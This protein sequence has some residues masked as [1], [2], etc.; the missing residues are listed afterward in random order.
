MGD[1]TEDSL[2]KQSEENVA[3]KAEVA[4]PAEKS[5]GAASTVDTKVDTS[6][7]KQ[8]PG[9]ETENKDS[10]GVVKESKEDVA[11]KEDAKP[12]DDAAKQQEESSSVK[13]LQQPGSDI[14]PKVTEAKD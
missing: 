1:Q 9:I 11:P 8:T 6:T 5:D 12:Q 4:K 7:P 3:P 14:S 13:N 2:P 10:A